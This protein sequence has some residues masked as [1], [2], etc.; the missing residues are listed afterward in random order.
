MLLVSCCLIHGKKV[1]RENTKHP[2][3]IHSVIQTTASHQYPLIFWKALHHMKFFSMK[4]IS[5]HISLCGKLKDMEYSLKPSPLWSLQQSLASEKIVLLEFLNISFYSLFLDFEYTRMNDGLYSQYYSFK[6]T[7]PMCHLYFLFYPLL[8]LLE[9]R[10]INTKTAKK[11]VEWAQ[12]NYQTGMLLL[13][14]RVFGELYCYQNSSWM[15]SDQWEHV[16]QY[17]IFLFVF[18]ADST[19][20][21]TTTSSHSLWLTCSVMTCALGHREPSW[22]C[23]SLAALPFAFMLVLQRIT[24]D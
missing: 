11:K 17:L 18:I 20:T 23:C 9:K 8:K 22:P 1:F 10:V 24:D 13:T 14:W 5:I 3:C 16:L 7:W 2:M 21:F 15:I 12:S 19:S 4:I 6:K